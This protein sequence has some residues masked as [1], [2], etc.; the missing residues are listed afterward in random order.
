M[1]EKRFYWLWLV[2]IALVSMACTAAPTTISTTTTTTLQRS[3]ACEHLHGLAEQQRANWDR[4]ADELDSAFSNVDAFNNVDIS[5]LL[6]SFVSMKNATERLN[7]IADVWGY[8]CMGFNDDD[9]LY[10]VNLRLDVTPRSGYLSNWCTLMEQKG[11][12]DP[13]SG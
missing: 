10:G 4:A 13:C 1:S 2:L 11:L 9:D 6:P 3:V 7:E 12:S 5:D 8:T